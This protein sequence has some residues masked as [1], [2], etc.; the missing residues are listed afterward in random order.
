VATLEA[1]RIV[2]LTDD[3]SPSSEGTLIQAARHVTP[4]SIN[5]MA[6][7]AGGLVCVALTAE[8]IR[9]L[10]LALMPVR[11]RAPSTPAFAV[12][13]EARRGVTT[14]ISAADRARTIQVAVAE[15]TRPEDLISPGHVFPVCIRQGG[16][17]ER[18]GPAEAATDLVRRADLPPAAVTCAVLGDD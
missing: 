16:V 2:L 11:N 15:G 5:F 3:D 7:H 13:I 4:D 18:S 14:G 10:G 8:R 17:L 12:S 9:E 6:S 1:G